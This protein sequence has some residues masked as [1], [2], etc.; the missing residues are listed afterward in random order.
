MPCLIA[1]LKN[2]RLSSLGGATALWASALGGPAPSPQEGGLAPWIEGSDL[3]VLP[4]FCRVPSCSPTL[5]A[6][7]L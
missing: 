3:P 1:G 2:C 5:L 6:D 7:R 4:P